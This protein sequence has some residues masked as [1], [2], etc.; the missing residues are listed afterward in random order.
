MI[1]IDCRPR[2]TLPFG[3]RQMVALS[4]KTR[5]FGGFAGTL[6]LRGYNT[7]VAFTDTTAMSFVTAALQGSSTSTVLRVLVNCSTSA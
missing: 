1:G 6:M 3:V 5:Q 2:E 7:L 4:T